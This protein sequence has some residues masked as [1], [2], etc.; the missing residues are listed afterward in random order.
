MT[1]ITQLYWLRVALGVVAGLISAIA[2][3]MLNYMTDLT[4]LFWSI[5]IALLIYLVTNY[6]FR[7]I[8][9]DKVEK[10]S[11]IFSTAIGMYFFT[12]IAFWV[13]FYTAII[14]FFH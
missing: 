2:S 7:P 14:S 13:L 6:I 11:K 4:P 10:P 3:Y 8:Y 1:P 12:W 9:K 5:T